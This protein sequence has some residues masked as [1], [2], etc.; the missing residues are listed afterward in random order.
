MEGKGGEGKRGEWKGR[1]RQGGRV[2]YPLRIY[3]FSLEYSMFYWSI[4]CVK[5]LKVFYNDV[6]GFVSGTFYTSDGQRR[7]VLQ[8]SVKRF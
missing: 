6:A 7:Y 1:E 2:E 8:C 5:L 4:Y 3:K